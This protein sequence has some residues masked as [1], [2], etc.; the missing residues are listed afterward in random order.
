M[1]TEILLLKQL[2]FTDLVSLRDNFKLQLSEC[3][4]TNGLPKIDGESVDKSIYLKEEIDLVEGDYFKME[5][6]PSGENMTIKFITY[7]KKNIHKDQGDQVINY[8]PEFDKITVR[9]QD[10]INKMVERF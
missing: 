2:S 3:L 6:L 5:Y 8:D 9:D 10:Y 1:S 4:D 7:G